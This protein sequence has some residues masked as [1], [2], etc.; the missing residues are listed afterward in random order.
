MDTSPHK[1]DFINSNGVNLHYLDW[2]GKGDALIFLTG[3]GCSAHLFDHIAPRFTDTLR[4]LAL[5]R[6]GQGESDYPETGYDIDTLVDDIHNFMEALKI[7]KASFAGHSLAGVELSYFAQKYPQKVIRLIF[8]DAVYDSKGRGEIFEHDPLREIQNPNPKTEF[9]SVE[10][11][12]E[13]VKFIRPDLAQIWNE[14]WDEV[15]VFDLTKDA[16]GK[17]IE[18]DTS[19]IGKQILDAMII[20]DSKN[21]NI[22]VPVLSF[23]AIWEPLGPGHMTEEQKQKLIE[24]ERTEWRPFQEREMELFKK[25]I[26]QAKVIEIPNSNHYCFISDEDLVYEEMRK[27][28]VG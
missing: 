7:E 18:K 16:L 22:M 28:L 4:V 17:Y 26:P 25:Y 13:Y 1:S 15:I 6:R 3:M 5:T 14:S 21:A 10:E 12:G 11:Y 19:S 2:G 24:F 27:F 9:L 20:Y 8:L 23:V